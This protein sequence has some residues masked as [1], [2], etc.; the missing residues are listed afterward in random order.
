[1]GTG[2]IAAAVAIERDEP[3]AWPA[4]QIEAEF[5]CDNSMLLVATADETVVGWCCARLTGD[6]AELLKIGVAGAWRR[7]SVATALMSSL[8]DALSRSKVGSLRLEVRSQNQGALGFYRRLG[9]TPVG[10]R[11]NYYSQPNDDALLLCRSVLHNVNS[12]NGL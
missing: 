7:R 1:M 4:S 8:L 9:F 2:D 10:R 11:I 3:S 5:F 6:E 12:R